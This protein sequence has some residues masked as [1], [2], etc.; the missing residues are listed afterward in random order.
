MVLNSVILSLFVNDCD[1]FPSSLR[2]M[3]DNENLC[4]QDGGRQSFQ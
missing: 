2:E 3:S 4:V 1:V